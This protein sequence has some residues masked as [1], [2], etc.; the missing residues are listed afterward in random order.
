[1]TRRLRFNAKLFAFVAF[2]TCPAVAARTHEIEISTNGTQ[3]N[4]D[5]KKGTGVRGYVFV[6]NGHSVQWTCKMNDRQCDQVQITFNRGN[7]CQTS[8]L[9]PT[10]TASCDGISVNNSVPCIKGG[11]NNTCFPYTTAVWYNGQQQNLA[12]DPEFI[13][14]GSKGGTLPTGVGT[15]ALAFVTLFIGVA[16]GYLWRKYQAH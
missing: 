13:V 4:Y 7:P 11:S 15:G 2:L 3:F 10:A 1:M 14:D 9:G 8:V 12:E 16:G 6:K 5:H